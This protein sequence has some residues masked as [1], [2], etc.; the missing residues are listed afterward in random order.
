MFCLCNCV[1][2]RLPSDFPP[3]VA[4]VD[5]SAL[6]F[7]NRDVPEHGTEGGACTLLGQGRGSDVYM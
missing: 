1:N 4:E 7:V 3:S 5:V 6:L 2:I